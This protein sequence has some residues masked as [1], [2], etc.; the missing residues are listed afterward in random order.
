[1]DNNKESSI[2]LKQSGIWFLI[3]AFLVLVAD[4][5]SKQ[6]I[7]TNIQAYNFAD[8]IEVIPNFW[9]II[10]V[11]NEGAAFSFLAEHSGWQQI[12]FSLLA[13]FISLYL[14]FL[15]TKNK[16]NMLWKNIS[17]ALVIGGACGNLYD[18]LAY[19]YVIDFLDFFVVYNGAEHHYPAFNIAD[20]GICV[21]VFMLVVYEF[22]MNKKKSK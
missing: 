16:A 19:N 22:F 20:C 2:K 18:R 14:V 10:H 5:L 15:L 13:V 8:F 1:M 7:V 9:R 3:L 17:Y 6:W 12:F 4:Y 11:H 21:G